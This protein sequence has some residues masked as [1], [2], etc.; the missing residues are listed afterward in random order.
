MVAV[1]AVSATAANPLLLDLPVACSVGETCFI[2]Q[3]F[4]HDPGP[5][6]SDYTCG[7]M[8]YDGHD[9][10]DIRLPTVAAMH[11]GVDVLAAAAGHG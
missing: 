10:V 2:Q 4:D 3:Y 7:T 5:G 1:V 9:G 8:S 11:K 6:A